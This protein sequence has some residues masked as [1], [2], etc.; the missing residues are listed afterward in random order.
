MPAGR[1]ELSNTM[2]SYLEARKAYGL[3]REKLSN[4]AKLAGIRISSA[5]IK[6][7]EDE[8]D[9]AVGG[10]GISTEAVAYLDFVLGL[11][12]AEPTDWSSIQQGA[13]VLVNGQKGVYSFVSEADGQVT[14]LNGKIA[15]VASDSARPAAR[16]GVPSAENAHLFEARTRGDGGTYA[17]QVMNYVQS[18]AEQPHSV[19]AISYALSLDNGIV[20]RTV[21]VLVKSGKLE[22]VSR[23]VVKLAGGEAAMTDAEWEA[24]VNAPAEEIPQF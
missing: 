7:L 8:G 9:K 19:G 16:S 1:K 24:S 6:K 11:G 2:S 20:S 3:S 10:R 13:P 21:A 14:L 17:R 4:L 18:H 22:K 23:G 5:S 15:T 12:A